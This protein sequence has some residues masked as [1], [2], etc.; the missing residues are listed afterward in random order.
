[1]WSIDY[2]Q[3]PSEGNETSTN[4][5]APIHHRLV[6]QV[7]ISNDSSG[8]LMKSGSES[9]LSEDTAAVR[10]SVESAKEW[11]KEQENEKEICSD[12]EENQLPP[13]VAAVRRRRSRVAVGLRKS[14]GQYMD[15][16]KELLQKYFL[17]D[18]WK[19]C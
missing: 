15:N 1:M 13:P 19:Q 17:F 3:V 4:K 2:V 9:S 12:I 8:S 5:I 16:L 7:H 10:V 11:R 18:R 6:K 14:E